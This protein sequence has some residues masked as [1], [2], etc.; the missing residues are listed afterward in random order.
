MILVIWP[1]TLKKK[2]LLH[3]VVYIER[4]NIPIESFS[5]RIV[6]IELSAISEVDGKTIQG[7]Y[8]CNKVGD[9]SMHNSYFYI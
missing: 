6:F 3:V 2:N 7:L 5:G 1:I 8:F 9:T 4:V